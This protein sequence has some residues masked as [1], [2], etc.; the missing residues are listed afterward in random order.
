MK[1]MLLHCGNLSPKPVLHTN[2]PYISGL[3]AKK[4]TLSGRKCRQYLTPAWPWPVPPSD[5]QLFLATPSFIVAFVCVCVVQTERSILLPHGGRFSAAVDP[6]L[7]RGRCSAHRGRFVPG[8]GY[9]GYTGA[10]ALYICR[11][12][13]RPFGLLTVEHV[14]L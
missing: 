8:R 5:R 6:Y 12:G 10:R 4:K 14:V 11:L 3:I 1:P 13:L 7:S 2:G 9:R